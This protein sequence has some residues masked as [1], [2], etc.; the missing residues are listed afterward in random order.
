MEALMLNDTQDHG[1]YFCLAADGFLHAL[2][3]HGDFEA[4]E[5]TALCQGLQ[6]VWLFDQATARSWLEFLQDRLIEAGAACDLPLPDGDFVLRDGAAWFS[7]KGA[8]VR[9]ASTDEGVAVDVYA[10]GQESEAPLGGTWVL[11][12]EIAEVCHV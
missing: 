8:S 2:G 11:D 12:T 10:L 7:V 5:D 9:I 4:A 6:S 1:L 3:D